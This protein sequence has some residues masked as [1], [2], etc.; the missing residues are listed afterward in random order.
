MIFNLYDFG[1]IHFFILPS[2]PIWFSKYIQNLIGYF[3]YFGS[4]SIFLSILLYKEYLESKNF[5]FKFLLFISIFIS[6]LVPLIIV[7][8]YFLNFNENLLNLILFY[9]FIINGCIVFLLLIK[10]VIKGF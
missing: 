7:L 1:A 9:I 3:A 6:I 4:I 5:I 2:S 8:N 10:Q